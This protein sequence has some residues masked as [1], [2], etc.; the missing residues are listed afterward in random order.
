MGM[1]ET[2]APKP[3]R[4]DSLS[5]NGLASLQA[6]QYY[7]SSPGLPFSLSRFF[8][9]AVAFAATTVKKDKNF[10]DDKKSCATR[11]ATNAP[12]N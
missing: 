4:M 8:L 6:C 10:A 1:E 11:I 3:G 5:P 2:P 12:P 7:V 9:S